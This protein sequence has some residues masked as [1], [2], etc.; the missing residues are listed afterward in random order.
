[1]ALNIPAIPIA[2]R[3]FPFQN[4]KSEMGNSNNKKGCS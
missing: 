1:M 3:S 4:K 2:F